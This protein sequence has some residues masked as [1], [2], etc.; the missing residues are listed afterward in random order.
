MSSPSSTRSHSQI[1]CS[2]GVDYDDAD[3]DAK[4][5]DPLADSSMAQCSV[6]EV[7]CHRKCFGLADIEEDEAAEPTKTGE[8]F[9]TDDGSQFYC[10]AEC[11]EDGDKSAN[12]SAKRKRDEVDSPSSAYLSVRLVCLSVCLSVCLTVVCLSD[13]RLSV[14]LRNLHCACR[15]YVDIA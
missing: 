9:R 2:C 11:Q 8:V 3:E 13:S 7:W 6:C 5:K 15:A 1:K 4:H 14:L 12:A 10:S